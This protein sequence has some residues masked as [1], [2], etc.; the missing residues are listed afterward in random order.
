MDVPD[1]VAALR[2]PL[3]LREVT[4]PNRAMVSAL[5][6]QYGRDGVMTERHAA[7]YRERADGGAGLLLT[8]QLSATPISDGPFSSPIAAYDPRQAAG[9]ER[10]LRA[11]DGRPT[12]FFAQLFAGGAAGASQ[13]GIDR[14]AP[15]R[16]PSRIGVPGGETPLPLTV[17]EIE[18][19]AE[20]FARSARIAVDA[21]V[22]GIELHGA[23]GWLIGQFLSPFYN[24]REDDYGGDVAGRCRFALTLGRAVRAELGDRVPLGL[25]LTYDELIGDVGITPD[26]TLRQLDELVAG[27][28][29]DFFDLSIGGPHSTWH[30]IASMAIDEGYPLAFAARAKAAVGSRAAI[31]ASG[32]VLDPAAAAAAVAAGQV[33]VVAMSRAQIADPRLMTPGDEP[34]R[35]RTRCVG[36]NVC[37]GRALG[38]HPVSCV[39]NPAVGREREWGGRVPSAAHPRAIAVIG[40]GPAG[41]R[42]AATAAVRG[43]RVVVHERASRAGGHLR[44]LAGL[45]TRGAWQA[46]I[47]DLVTTIRRHGGELRLGTEIGPD[48]LDRF[49]ADALVLATGAPWADDGS[50]FGRP[51]RDAIPGIERIARVGLDEAIERTAVDGRALGRRVVIVDESG[52]YAPLGLA[53]RLAAHGARVELVTPAPAVGAVATTELELEPWLARVAGRGIELRTLTDIERVDVGRVW[54]RD[55]LAAAPTVLEDVDT[56]VLALRRVPADALLDAAEERGLELHAVGDVVSPRPTDA[57]IHDAE[58]LARRL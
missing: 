25:S 10:V 18:V 8:E 42:V 44:Q 19:I 38:G 28:V 41:L 4:L 7:F 35:V 31:L 50:R 22:H 16:A 46:A 24:R 56:L 32:R 30:T 13:V 55:A 43:H 29:Y 45:P 6:L 23:H 57:V 37:V 5:T 2:E 33:D 53:E 3:R 12:R 14:W 21:G 9:Y 11:L 47:D 36:A 54:L 51:D 20:D 17:A 52:A 40:A 15:L 34:G 48:D 27:D 26:D 1:P 49:E 39:V 58:A